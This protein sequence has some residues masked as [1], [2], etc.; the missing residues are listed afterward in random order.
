MDGERD[1]FGIVDT[2]RKLRDWM[3]SEFFWEAWR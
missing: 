2:A 3:N 1:N